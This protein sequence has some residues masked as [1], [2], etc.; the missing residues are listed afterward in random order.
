M[1]PRGDPRKPYTLML[2][3]TE[4]AQLERLAEQEM[5]TTS[6]WLRV[7]ITL[8]YKRQFGDEKPVTA[9]PDK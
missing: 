6:D 4:R 7:H 8:A 3:V 1:T 5:R 9:D 2:T